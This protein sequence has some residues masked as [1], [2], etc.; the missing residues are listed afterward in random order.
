MDGLTLVQRLKRSRSREF[1]YT[2]HSG[3]IEWSRNGTS[4]GGSSYLRQ[5]KNNKVVVV[6]TRDTCM[7]RGGYLGLILLGMCRWPLGALTPLQ[8]I[9]WP[10]IDPI[11]VT[12][13]KICNFCDPNLV[14]FF[15][16][17]YLISNEEHSTFHQQYKHSGTFANC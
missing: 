14:T 11:L 10:I 2:Q 17:I 4:D 13:G 12:L 3:V 7:P 6:N 8:S 9:L 1:H 5:L 15:L 16:C